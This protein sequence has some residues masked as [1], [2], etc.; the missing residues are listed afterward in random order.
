MNVT[1]SRSPLMGA[2][3][4]RRERKLLDELLADHEF[5]LHSNQRLNAAGS[6]AAGSNPKPGEQPLDAVGIYR[7]RILRDFERV[8]EFVAKDRDHA[9]GDRKRNRRTGQ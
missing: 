8:L 2:L 7:T 9:T 1:T 5:D 4:G 3:G 6:L